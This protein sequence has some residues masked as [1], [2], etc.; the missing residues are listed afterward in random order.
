M[1]KIAA[2]I[3]ARNLNAFLF[4]KHHQYLDDINA[5]DFGLSNYKLNSTDSLCSNVKKRIDKIAGHIV[6]SEPTPFKD[7][8]EI[9]TVV[10]SILKLSYEFVSK[11]LSQGKAKYTGMAPKYVDHLND[12]LPKI[13]LSLELPNP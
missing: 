7:D 2:L 13:G 8:E 10:C 3:M 6:S 11:C 12:F 4:V 9:K 5:T 1:A